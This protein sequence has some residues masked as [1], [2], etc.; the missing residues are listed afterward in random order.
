MPGGVLIRD[1]A[2]LARRRCRSVR[3]LDRGRRKSP[4]HAFVERTAHDAHTGLQRPHIMR[5]FA[6][7]IRTDEQHVA[8]IEHFLTRKCELCGVSVRHY[9]KICGEFR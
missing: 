1:D 9:A 6:I 3:H 5:H 4:G 2:R 7:E 8:H